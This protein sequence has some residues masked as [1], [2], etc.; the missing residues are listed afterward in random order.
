MRKK[1][2][3][4]AGLAATVLAGCG[5]LGVG[6]VAEGRAVYHERCVMCHGPGG[7]GDGDFAKELIKMPTDLTILARENGGE[8]PRL[9]AIETID[10]HARG[11]HFSGAMPEFGP[12][13]TEGQMLESG[14]G[15]VTP[16]PAQLVAVVDYLESIQE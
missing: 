12:L 4:V 14:A 6:S 11:R 2:G 1:I 5:G 8:F 3:L 15:Q 16:A 7:K 9:W 10:G 13:L